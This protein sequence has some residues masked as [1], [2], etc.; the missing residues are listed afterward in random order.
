MRYSE[1]LQSRHGFRCIKMTWMSPS[2]AT[3][4]E[5]LIVLSGVNLRIFSRLEP[6]P[7]EGEATQTTFSRFDVV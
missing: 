3:F 4:L 7:A 1:C 2:C 6:F 5:L